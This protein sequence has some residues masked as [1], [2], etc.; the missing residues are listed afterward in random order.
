MV[1]SS[2]RSVI[3]AASRSQPSFA[4]SR[5]A[6]A[7]GCRRSTTTAT[8]PETATTFAWKLG[9]DPAG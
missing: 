4:G 1:G 3:A 2:S 9:T 7:D 8:L 6:A 5:Y